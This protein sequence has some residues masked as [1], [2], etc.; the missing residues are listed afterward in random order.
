MRE[1]RERHEHGCNHPGRTTE[2]PQRR[3]EQQVQQLVEVTDLVEEEATRRK[4]EERDDEEPLADEP[5]A[6][7]GNDQHR[8]QR[9]ENHERD[10]C[11]EPVVVVGD[12]REW[13][14]QRAHEEAAVEAARQ[15]DRVE[16]RRPEVRHPKA[17]VGRQEDGHG[18]QWSPE[19]RTE[20]VREWLVC[21]DGF[22]RPERR[23]GLGGFSS[24]R[25][26]AFLLNGCW[27]AH[28]GGRYYS[29][30]RRRVSSSVLLCCGRR[31][32]GR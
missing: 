15:R 22:A 6:Q 28:H 1:H 10:G 4:Q 11:V 14:Q 16:R 20:R 2:E 29:T 31:G 8:E 21:G 12:L 27:P 3:E 18:Q 24:G 13:T 23:R 17:R 25:T 9:R 26:G 5:G 7:R 32:S 19:Q 30:A